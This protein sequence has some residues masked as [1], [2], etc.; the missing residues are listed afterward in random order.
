MWI[1]NHFFSLVQSRQYLI[2]LLFQGLFDISR[3]ARC[4]PEI[5]DALA[6]M[7]GCHTNVDDIRAFIIYYLQC[8]F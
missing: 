4:K 5:I 3:F 1:G 8:F 7:I 6:G 2:T